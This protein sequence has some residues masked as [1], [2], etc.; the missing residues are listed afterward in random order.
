MTYD[1]A[2]LLPQIDLSMK[3]NNS[4]NQT[5]LFAKKHPVPMF[6]A[7]IKKEIKSDK[8][9]FFSPIQQY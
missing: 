6:P 5:S 8:V 9:P 7:P 1:D 4:I 2:M 3:M